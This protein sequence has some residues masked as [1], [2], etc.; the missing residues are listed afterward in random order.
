MKEDLRLLAVQQFAAYDLQDDPELQQLVFMAAE[1]C[2]VPIAAV[3]LIEGDNQLVK[4]K[5]GL[6]IDILPRKISFSTHAMDQNG[7]MI[8]PDLLK[9]GRFAD[10]PLV[11]NGPKIRFYAGVPLI[12]REGFRLGTFCVGDRKPNTLN[13]HQQM[14]L[15]MLAKQAVNV[16]ELKFSNDQLKRNARELHEQKL[17]NAEAEIRLRSF[18]ENSAN[19]HVLLGKKGEVIDYNKTAY[20]FI[21]NTHS[22]KLERGHLLLQ[23]LAE[24]FKEVFLRNYELALLGVRSVEEGSTNYGDKGG[25]I[26]WEAVF[27]PARDNDDKIVGISYL[28]TNTTK[29][30]LY[31]EKILQQNQSLLKIAHIQS[32][33]IRGPL[34][35]IIGMMNV[36][37]M[38]AHTLPQEYITLLDD[39]VN[40]L[41]QKIHEILDK[42]SKIGVE[43][44]I[45]NV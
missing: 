22:V 27:E 24:D 44:D 5:I 20:N 14:M 9:D 4:V 19:F 32:H 11:K 45:L 40:R 28:I 38:E 7:I 42:V 30:K 37:K 34:T 21:R 15:T 43:E 29:R 31:E 25:L 8:V 1:I 3:N 13:E 10:N 16:M 2:K 6:N 17:K 12:S 33:E 41:D 35:S 39:A 23:Y 26:Y 18:F 36:I